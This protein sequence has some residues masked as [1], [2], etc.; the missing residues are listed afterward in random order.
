MNL[1]CRSLSFV[2]LTLVN[3]MSLKFYNPLV[4]KAMG[5]D[6]IS[7]KLLKQC[8]L[9]L[10]RSLHYLFSLSLSQ[11]YL[12]LE[13]RTHLIKPVFKSGDKNSIKKIGLYLCYL[14]YLKYWENLFTTELWISY[15][16][17]FKFSIWFS[18]WSI[19]I[20]AVTC[21]FQHNILFLFSNRCRLFRF[22]ESF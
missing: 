15:L 11:S 4:S 8:S 9:S 13:W 14:L 22:Q 16:L 6:G 17:Y 20:T 12:P 21:L 3:Q 5:N 10:Y 19:Y 1:T 18:L 7:P 2:I